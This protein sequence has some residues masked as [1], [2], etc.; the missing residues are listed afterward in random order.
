[1]SS[2]PT[3]PGRSLVKKML[4]P[5]GETT[6]CDS[7]YF[8]L[9]SELKCLGL[10]HVPSAPASETYRLPCNDEP[11]RKKYNFLPS[12]EIETADSFLPLVFIGA[13]SNSG[14]D[15]SPLSFFLVTKIF[16]SVVVFNAFGRL[17]VKYK[18]LPSQVI[19]G[20]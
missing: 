4:F 1:M 19:T 14:A 8:V 7:L 3:P 20:E 17:D 6:T 11:E 13:G 2:P 15:H 5:S 18:V 10:P 16:S 9:I 12:G